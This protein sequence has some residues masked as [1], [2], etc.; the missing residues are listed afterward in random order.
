MTPPNKG[1]NDG[2]GTLLERHALIFPDY[3]LF[4]TL[5]ISY[6]QNGAQPPTYPSEELIS[7]V[8]DEFLENITLVTELLAQYL[9]F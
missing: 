3:L 9:V 2:D 7:F 5:P 1:N 8:F 6:P 4:W